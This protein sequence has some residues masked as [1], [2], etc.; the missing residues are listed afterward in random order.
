MTGAD[1][2]VV[3]VA[4]AAT[5]GTGLGASSVTAAAAGGTASFSTPLTV[6]DADDADAVTSS[7]SKVEENR[8]GRGLDL[9]AGRLVVE[10]ENAV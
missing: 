3:D 8:G 4:T 5:A 10:K 2:V 1:V 7:F 9:A 6:E